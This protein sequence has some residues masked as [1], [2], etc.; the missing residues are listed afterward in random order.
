VT[1]D[2]RKT[3]KRIFAKAT[4]LDQSKRQAYLERVRVDPL[5]REEVKSLLA[6]HEKAENLMGFYSSCDQKLL[7]HYEVLERIGEGGMA[8]IYKARDMQLGRFVAIKVLPAWGMGNPTWRQRFKSEATRASA[9]NH[10]NIVTIHGIAEENGVDFIVMEFVD[11]KTLNRR[12]P[13]GGLSV[14]DTLNYAIPLADALVTAHEAGILHGDLKPL[15]LM[16]TDDDRIILL[17]FGL[18]QTLR[19][20]DAQVSTPKM[21]GKFGTR[22]YMAPEQLANLGAAPDPRSE[23]FSFGLILFEM[24][25]GRHAFVAFRS[26][27]PVDAILKKNP[28]NLPPKVP[29]TLASIVYRCLEKA[30]DQRFQSML[31][32]LF[33]LKKYRTNAIPGPSASRVFEPFDGT[34]LTGI[35]SVVRHSAE[36]RQ[37]R[38][39]IRRIGYENV[40]LSRQAVNEIDRLIR[41]SAS[42]AVREAATAD[43]K[44]LILISDDFGGNV[45]SLSAREVRKMVIELIKVSTQGN[46]SQCFGPLDLEYLDLYGMNF[47]RQALT[48][49]SFK[50]CTLIEAK[51]QASNL[52]RTSFAEAAVRNADFSQ[53][54]LSG[55][56]LT[57]A[58]WFNAIGLTESQLERVRRETVMKCPADLPALHRY[59]RGRYRLPFESWTERVRHQLQAAWKEYLRPQGLRDVVAEWPLPNP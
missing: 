36:L 14:E 11:G 24:L 13:A 41:A 22:A 30:P 53:A 10:P 55:A 31:D 28:R 59:L 50:S 39:A 56:D 40:A 2:Q 48:G 51:F 9:V 27:D 32:L 1:F 43:L 3:L 35:Q 20:K 52:T 44:D 46:L 29:D 5:L 12:I 42:S 6:Q 58:D 49:I 37:I 18:A 16:V 54:D 4:R 45:V 25:C 21:Q 38:T 8:S 33:E 26:S 19:S 7:G 57:D 17:D 15:N 34:E 47:E 23:I